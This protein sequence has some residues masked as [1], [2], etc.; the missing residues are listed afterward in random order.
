MKKLL[1]LPICLLFIGITLS[2][3]QNQLEFGYDSAGN[4]IR[5]NWVCINCKSAQETAEITDSIQSLTQEDLP[6]NYESNIVAYPNP[7]TDF[8]QIEWIDNPLR[9]PKEIFLY[10]MN[11]Q[12][13][14]EKEIYSKNG[15]LEIPLEHHP[16]GMY[17]LLVVYQNG[18]KKSFN[19]LKK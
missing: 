4:Q 17:I 19:I 1:L 2:S 16:S 14:Y 10:S 13:I 15:S 7:T 6:T 12:L 8:L 9:Q 5:R 11:S 3:A 18:D